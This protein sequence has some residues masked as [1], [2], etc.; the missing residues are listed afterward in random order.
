MTASSSVVKITAKTALKGKWL[1]SAVAGLVLVFCC[2]IISFVSSIL[3]SIVGNIVYWAFGVAS[4]LFCI[5]PL[6]LG[7]LRY[8]WRLLNSA[9]DELSIIFYYFSAKELYFKSLHSSFSILGRVILFGIVYF[10]PTYI[11]GLFSDSAVY[12]FLDI[13]IPMFMSN[14]WLI[15]LILKVLAVVALF[16]TI[17]RY[18]LV[19][20]F[21]VA[22]EEMDNSEA[23]HM[24]SV[25]FR[26]TSSDFIYLI[27]SFAG[28]ICLSIFIAPLVF[29]VPYMIT[30]YLIHAR[31]A[32]AEYNKHIE[33]ENIRQSEEFF[34]GL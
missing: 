20:F 5:F 21:I 11:T 4:A 22:D 15:S 25:I 19:P 17:S 10:I 29:T 9:D 26:A 28:W 1:K 16:F 33:N 34:S 12:E 24:S 3:Q 13:P 31:F 30:S 2:L 27:C 18:Y 8:F 32:V 7:V 6:F 23:I 14:F